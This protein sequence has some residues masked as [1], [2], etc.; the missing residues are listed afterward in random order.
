MLS[1]AVNKTQVTTNDGQEMAWT[2]IK[3]LID[4]LYAKVDIVD[5]TRA[6]ILMR[7]KILAALN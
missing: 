3:H 2:I 1:D 4:D 5:T 6:K 7:E